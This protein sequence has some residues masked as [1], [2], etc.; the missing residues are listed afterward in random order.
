MKATRVL[1]TE[2]QPIDGWRALTS[3]II[4]NAVETYK[5]NADTWQRLSAIIWLA[6]D[7]FPL[8]AEVAGLHTENGLK[9]L[10][11]NNDRQT[12]SVRAGS[13]RTVARPR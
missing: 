11:V 9:F 13:A 1:D 3:A 6:G 2:K 7:D 10:Q 8:F 4:L 12:T 5:H